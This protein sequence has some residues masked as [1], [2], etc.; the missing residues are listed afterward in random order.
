MNNIFKFLSITILI[1]FTFLY[2]EESKK[3]I[4]K[5]TGLIINKGMETVKM[6]CTVCHSAKFITLQRATR[7]GWKDMIVW[8][9][10]TQGLWSFDAVTEKT[11]LDY[12][13]TNYAPSGKFSRRKNLK[14]SEL[15]KNPYKTQ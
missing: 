3:A 2:S 1:F 13:S 12:L 14:D 11:I 8:M 7:K 4:D 10:K 5:N 15:P 6:H 9:Q